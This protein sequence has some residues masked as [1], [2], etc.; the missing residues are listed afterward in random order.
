MDLMPFLLKPGKKKKDE[1]ES[2]R[3]TAKEQKNPSFESKETY[4]KGKSA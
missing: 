1:K 2:K 3:E 4:K